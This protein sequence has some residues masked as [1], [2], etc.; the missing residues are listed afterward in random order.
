MGEAIDNE[1]ARLKGLMKDFAKEVV[2]GVVVIILDLDQNASSRPPYY[3]QMD[4]GLTVISLRPRDGSTAEAPIR[5][6]DVADIASIYKGPEVSAKVPHLGNDALSCVGL[7]MNRT[8]HPLLFYFDD[9]YERD[10]FYTCLQIV[11]MSVDIQNSN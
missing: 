1:K 5:E 11:R 8:N 7:D 3:F 2:G 6:F 10:K 4:R 9:K